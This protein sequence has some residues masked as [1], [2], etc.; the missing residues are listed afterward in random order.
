MVAGFLRACG[1]G[2]NEVVD[3]LLQKGVDIAAHQ[4]DGQTGLHWAAIGGQLE[5]VKLLLKRGAPLEMKNMY[6]GTVFGQ[7]LWSAAHGGD[8]DIY[9]QI[10]EA[11]IA[12]GAQVYDRHPPINKRIDDL[13]ENYGSLTDET[14]WWYGEK[15]KKR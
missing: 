12:A 10:I 15:P 7:T 14:L 8:P 1:Y 6:G 9:T 2:R 4:D 3:F 5:T 13:L 11:L